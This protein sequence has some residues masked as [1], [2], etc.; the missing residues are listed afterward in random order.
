MP[1]PQRLER[2]PLRT[3]LMA[4]LAHYELKIVPNFDPI[5][6]TLNRFPTIRFM[7]H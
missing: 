7:R 4:P 1:R 5:V 3:L 2:R 6:A